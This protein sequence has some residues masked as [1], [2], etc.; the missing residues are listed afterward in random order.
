MSNKTVSVMDEI[1]EIIRDLGKSHQESKE[2]MKALREAQR[3]TEEAVKKTSESIDKANG[4]FNNKWGTFLE[5]LIKGD[6][7]RLLRERGIQVAKTLPA[8]VEI[9]R[10]DGSIKAEYDLVVINGLEAVIVEVK[11]TLSNDKL[12]QFIEKL[13][14]VREHFSEISD[15]KIYAGIAYMSADKNSDK[16]AEEKG[17]FL[18]KAPGGS[19]KVSTIAN[20][21]DFTPKAF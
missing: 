10:K 12:D 13:N 19:V 15:K 18:I 14:K 4:N 11:T 9:K 16:R 7:D 20:A 5:N 1:R 6:L 2:E 8:G 17:L 21:P 3:N